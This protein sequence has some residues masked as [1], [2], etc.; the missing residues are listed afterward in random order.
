MRV[1]EVRSASDMRRFVFFPREL[2]AKNPF[3]VPPLWSDERGAYT[4]CKNAVLSH[5]DFV[6]LL[7]E[8]GGRVVGRS[9]VYVDRNF[10]RYYGTRTGL[11]GAFECVEDLCVAR[12]LDDAALQWLAER[13]MDRVR[14]PIHPV[15]ES[16]GFLLDGY[17]SPPVFMAPYNPPYYI[18]FMDA[19]GYGK[20]KDLL[21]YEASND[22]GYVLPRRF[23]E[24][25]DRI[26]R[27]SPGIRA[28]P[29][30]MKRLASEADAIWRI[31]NI[32]LKDNWGYV[33]LDRVELRDMLRRLKPIADPE[34]VW[35]LED[36]GVP[37]GFALGFPDLNVVLKR[38]G[39]R[40][41]PFGFLRILLGIKRVK[42]YR[43]FGLAILPEYHNKGLDVLLYRSL[44]LALQPRIRRMEANYILEDN[45]DIRNALEKLNLSLVKTY[46]VYEKSLSEARAPRA[47]APESA[48]EAGQALGGALPRSPNPR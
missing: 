27:G 20:A 25:I 43:L 30:D 28:R 40:L 10:N 21:A 16:W 11:F 45:M 26:M 31:S 8:D 35:F 23:E 34:A 47:A 6:L 1:N 2:Y 41:L 36:D 22:R 9:L 42:D 29:I 32:A 14:G 44:Y 12:A 33:P 7:A 24:Y 13:G 38:I 18:P 4:R 3:W 37:V 19:L 39:G 5:S 15:A 46:R 48:P 17:R